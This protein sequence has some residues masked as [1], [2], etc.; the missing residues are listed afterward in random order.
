MPNWCNDN[1]Q[2]T[3]KDA[4]KIDARVKVLESNGDVFNHISPMPEELRQTTAPNTT[5]SAV[6]MREK[7]GYSDWYDWAVNNWGTKWDADVHSWERDGD[8][9]VYISFNTAWAP[10]IELYDKMT[11]EG[12]EVNGTYCEEGMCFV[13]EYIDGIENY[14]EYG[15][16]TSDTI[17]DYIPEHLD[18]EY[19]ISAYMSECEDEEE[20]G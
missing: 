4:A 13:G 1:D 17:I 3:N 10:P 20:V 5:E 11:A 16:A 7:Y 6:L 9:D 2:V 19:G 14:Y 15:D 18:E 8:N 12:W